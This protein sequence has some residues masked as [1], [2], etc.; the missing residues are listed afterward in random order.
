VTTPPI[1][2]QP[3]PQKQAAQSTADIIFFGGAKGGG[4]S[5]WGLHESAKWFDLAGHSSIIFRRTYPELTGDGSLWEEASKLY[6][7][8]GGEM[9]ESKMRCRFPSGSSVAFRHLQHTKDAYA[10]N[11]KNIGDVFFDELPFFEEEQFWIVLSC[12]RALVG[13]HAQR[14]RVR[15][16]MNPDPDSWVLQFVEWYL[17]DAGF[18]D[19]AKSGVIRWFGRRDG[20]LMWFA[21]AAEAIAAGVDR[22][23]S[24][25][26]ISSKIWDNPALLDARPDYLANLQAL[27]P[28]EQ[29]RYLGGNWRVRAQAGD[30]FREEWFPIRAESDFM[31]ASLGQPLDRQ[32]VRRFRVWDLAGTPWEGDTVLPGTPAR[33]DGPQ[34]DWTRGGLFGLTRDGLLILLDMKSWRDSPGAIEA[35]VI[36]TAKEDGPAVE[37]VVGHDPGQ[38]GEY[39]I[40]KLER[41]IRRQA[42]VRHFHAVRATKGKEEYAAV[43]SRFAYRGRIL[44]QRGPHA[45]PF[46]KELEGFPG[47]IPAGRSKAYMDQ[48][49]VLSQAV[50]FVLEYMG[51]GLSGILPADASRAQRTLNLDT[52]RIGDLLLP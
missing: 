37:V 49:D 30:Y 29:A 27:P 12:Q 11:G 34:P 22:P 41:E 25:T 43:A 15:A 45:Q 48:V 23:K 16:T 18:A 6:P 24:F 39:Q 1:A 38:A 8:L 50:M 3:G 51:A 20:K 42:K 19:P 40:E 26:F 4:K 21:S 28:V 47:R 44:V 52:R 13:G 33:S 31:R 17:D 9:V 5:R 36:R 32:I 10:W 2:L 35:A 14:P 46:F 7:L